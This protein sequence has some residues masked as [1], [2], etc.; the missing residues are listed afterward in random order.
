[1]KYLYKGIIL[2]TGVINNKS[3][4]KMKKTILIAIAL[5]TC[6]NA[7]SADLIV[8]EFGA[9]SSYTSISSAITAATDGDRI[10]I[11][12]R[13]GNIPWSENLTV[14][15]SLSLLSGQAD[16]TFLL[17][18]NITIMPADNREVTII[19]A[20]IYN[21]KDIIVQS[22][23]ITLR[24]MKLNIHGSIFDKLSANNE[25]II[26]QVA[27]NIINQISISYGDIIGNEVTDYIVVGNGTN[28]STDLSDT[29][30]V[31]GNRI[32]S[33]NPITN[34]AVSYYG[35]GE[36][37]FIKNNLIDYSISGSYNG[38]ITGKAVEVTINN[39]NNIVHEITN[40]N[41][42]SHVANT[43][44]ASGSSIGAGAYTLYITATK[45]SIQNNILKPSANTYNLTNTYFLSSIHASGAEIDSYF[46]NYSGG[47]ASG[48]RNDLNNGTGSVFV[49]LGN[50]A[51]IFNDVDLTRNDQGEYGGP[52][53]F[54]NFHP[55]L[56]GSTRVYLVVH[57]FYIRQG[58]T[59]NVRAIG[60]DR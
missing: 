53:T 10:I 15:K 19:G 25:G 41:I 57:P 38:M 28:G 34:S 17:D 7:K 1:M 42:S 54:S 12:N 11:K 13:F 3:S 37:L 4:K 52:F 20:E 21:N 56:A 40:N 29:C 47:T 46:N 59:L 30:Y 43:Y 44:A 23:A 39:T 8:E 58:S 18:G 26:C 32:N 48:L 16:S 22:G 14:N 2:T 31:I 24:S 51:P 27:G 5:T 50:P 9:P 36:H 55:V 45:A 6:Y 35:G 60:Y 33:S 49:D